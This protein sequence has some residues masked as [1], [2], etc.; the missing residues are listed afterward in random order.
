MS[1]LLFTKVILTDK[2][3]FYSINLDF[4]WH[5]FRIQFSLYKQL[6]NKSWFFPNIIFRLNGS[7]QAEMK[8]AL[9]VT[10]EE[11][12]RPCIDLIDKLRALGVEQDV[13]LPTIAVV[14]DQSAGKSSVLEAISGV[15]LPR[16]SGNTH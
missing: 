2:C 11:S 10:Y 7:H 5:Y 14:G 9:H 6:Y 8:P 1:P 12:I 13:H 3:N 15:Q 16:G 4:I